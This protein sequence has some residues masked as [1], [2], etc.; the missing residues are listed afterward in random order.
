MVS[1]QF[2][3]QVAEILGQREVNER[4]LIEACQNELF[5]H[6]DDISLDHDDQVRYAEL[7]GLLVGKFVSGSDRDPANLVSRFEKEILEA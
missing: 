6:E 4:G 1:V 3:S 7:I 5:R 2:R